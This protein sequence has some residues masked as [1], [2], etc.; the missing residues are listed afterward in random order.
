[1]YTHRD[2]VE[3]PTI[4][5]IT[6]KGILFTFTNSKPPSHIFYGIPPVIYFVKKSF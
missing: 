1:M 2:N 6:P 5:N 4:K 3:K